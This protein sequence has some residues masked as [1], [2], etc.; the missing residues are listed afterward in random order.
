MI[1]SLSPHLSN[2]QPLT[3]ELRITKLTEDEIRDW[4]VNNVIY[5]V[6]SQMPKPLLYSRMKTDFNLADLLSINASMVGSTIQSLF[7]KGNQKVI[8]NDT[9][10]SY[11]G[12]K[13]RQWRN[14]DFK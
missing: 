9:K 2:Q 13:T 6:R 14:L 1:W 11:N 7:S 8:A 3:S 4:L 5:K 10:I 12:K